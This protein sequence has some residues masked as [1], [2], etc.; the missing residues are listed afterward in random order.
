MHC[1]AAHRL[2]WIVLVAG[3]VAWRLTGDA[4]AQDEEGEPQPRAPFEPRAVEILFT[5]GSN[6]RLHLADEPIELITPHGKLKIP[7]E[8]V[9]RIEFAQRLNAETQQQIDDLLK[10]LRSE[11]EEL[12]SAATDGLLQ[13]GAQ[14]YPAVAKAAR[15][16]DPAI[17]P[18]AAEVL[19]HLRAQAPES[20]R[21]VRADD[22]VETPDT[23]VAGQIVNPKIKLLTAQFG[24]LAMSLADAR[25]LRH[26]SYIPAEQAESEPEGVLPDPGN[27]KAYEQRIGETLSFTVTAA[28]G[29]SVWGTDI[30]TTDTRLSTAV[31]HAGALKEGET[32]VVRVKIV[33][34]QPS[35]AGSARNG[36]TSSGYGGYGGSYE[37]LKPEKDPGGPHRMRMMRGGLRMMMPK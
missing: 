15:S 13:F 4:F 2:L 37:I 7:A 5:D 1:V 29:G 14:A 21:L 32:G 26:Q 31:I 35:Y 20:E 24:E 22:L 23:K 30:Y 34:G 6:L 18:Y 17:A 12:R 8:D 19:A 3:V 10:Q 27:L 16:G 33:A 9:L 25:S 36:V 11:D 28:S